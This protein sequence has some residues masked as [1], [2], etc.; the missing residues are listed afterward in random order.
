LAA[1][2]VRNISDGADDHE[3]DSE[4]DGARVGGVRASVAGEAAAAA[5]ALM[6]AAGAQDL[7][8]APLFAIRMGNTM[9]FRHVERET[10]E[11]VFADIVRA[12]DLSSTTAASEVMQL[13]AT[14]R[15]VARTEV[16]AP[17]FL[18][19]DEPPHVPAGCPRSR[20]GTLL[21]RGLHLS[22]ATVGARVA[23]E[24]AAVAEEMTA[25]LGGYDP[26]ASAFHDEA[27]LLVDSLGMRAPGVSLLQLPANARRVRGWVEHLLASGSLDGPDAPVRVAVKT[28]AA[29]VAA[30]EVDPSAPPVDVS[31]GA[32]ER[33]HYR[34]EGVRA[35]LWAIAQVVCGG[36]GRQTDTASLTLCTS[37]ARSRRCV[38]VHDGE[39]YSAV[40]YSKMTPL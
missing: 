16:V 25:L 9:Y 19:G 28:S 10:A 13:S 31:P 32:V 30:L 12:T 11:E 40:T 38:Y 8:S 15:A 27:R 5:A 36:P 3:A 1:A 20:C 39:V 37:S 4:V 18:P 14:A 2:R 26:T 35:R 21:G 29:A 22:S 24:Q 23:S 33:F 6:D 7:A 17:A 34:V